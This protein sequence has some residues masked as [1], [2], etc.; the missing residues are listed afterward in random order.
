MVF[1]IFNV[2]PP[3]PPP[4]R[5]DYAVFD[6]LKIHEETVVQ[7]LCLLPKNTEDE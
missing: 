3:T 5:S 2:I 7:I 4:Y 6:F 1:F